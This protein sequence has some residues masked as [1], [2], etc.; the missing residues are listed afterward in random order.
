MVASPARRDA[1]DGR[2]PRLAGA[3]RPLID[4]VAAM[5][6][7]VHAKLLAGFLVGVVLLLAL[8]VLS[9]VVIDRMSARVGEIALLQERVD[10]A[11]QM[12]DQI[13]ATSHYRAMALLTND[14]SNNDK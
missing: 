12:E 8:A 11:R 7:S 3:L 14:E 1:A 9:L 6:L 5:R 13:N 10:R 4:A 2:L